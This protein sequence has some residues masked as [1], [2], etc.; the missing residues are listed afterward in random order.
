MFVFLGYLTAAWTLRIDLVASY[1]CRVLGH[2]QARGLKEFRALPPPRDMP[3]AP[4]FKFLEKATYMQ[5][6]AARFFM[7]GTAYPYTMS[8]R[9]FP[10]YW[11]FHYGALQDQWIEFR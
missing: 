7:Q 2:M 10:D 1:A 11:T 9:Y 8:T 3:L 4:V 5:R 6:S